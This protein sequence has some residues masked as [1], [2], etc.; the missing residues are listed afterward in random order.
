MKTIIWD[1]NGTLLDDAETC[2]AVM[3]RMLTRRGLPP[4]AD[5]EHYREIFTFPVK[6]YYALAGLDLHREPFKELAAEYMADYTQ[7][8]RACTLRSGAV[9][10]IEELRGM[11]CAQF[12]ASASEQSDLDRQLE[13][14]GLTGR[15][16]AALGISDRLGGGKAGL[17]YRY[18]KSCEIPPE[19]VI[20][21]GDTLHDFEVAQSIGC[22]CILLAGGHQSRKKLLV[23]GA[24]VLE[25][26][27]EIKTVIKL[28]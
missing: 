17:A 16:E 2:R 24:P 7:A 20:F 28:K 8:A 5:L 23:S 4:I 22:A 15:F 19:N 6:D 18:L 1:W 13:E 11:G 3:N 26:L 12:L 25:E 9:E 14:Q 10:V 21:I 27:S